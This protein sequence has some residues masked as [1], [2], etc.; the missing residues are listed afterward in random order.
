MGS[1]Y[2][3]RLMKKSRFPNRRP[4]PTLMGLS[5]LSWAL[6]VYSVNTV[7]EQ[8]V[9]LAVVVV[10]LNLNSRDGQGGNRLLAWSIPMMFLYA[11]VS[12][13]FG[14]ST[15]PVLWRGPHIPALGTL[16]LTAGSIRDSLLRTLRIWDLLTLMIVLMR[17]IR[18]DDISHWLGRRF[19]R[20]S[21]TL[22]MILNFMPNLIAERSRV[23]D[24]VMF[25][26]D[27]DAT[28]PRMK[29]LRAHGVVY[30]T[31]L[32]NALE[33][34]WLLAESM[35][36]RGYGGNG[37]TNYGRPRWYRLDVWMGYAFVLSAVAT[38]IWDFQFRI[39][40]HR[41]LELHS[42][43]WLMVGLQGICLLGLGVRMRVRRADR[44][45]YIPVSGDRAAGD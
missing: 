21:L 43:E 35:H 12:S 6:A 33:R 38:I 1:Q 34:S 23:S 32:M 5:A 27:M 20:I 14:T 3:Q 44:T 45:A 19:T 41:W 13:L 25:R 18:S 8:G 17:S 26:G 36:V 2:G 42:G 40:D 15:G 16:T 28:T 29:R 37:R 39:P 7:L 31:L 30:Q 10:L 9:M 11:L 22:S 24:M 4:H